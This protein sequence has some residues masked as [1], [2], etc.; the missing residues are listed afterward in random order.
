MNIY[1]YYYNDNQIQKQ[2]IENK[3]DNVYKNK[4]MFNF[5]IERVRLIKKTTL[6][7]MV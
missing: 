1:I 4:M 6:K 7:Q 3:I 2:S 5:T